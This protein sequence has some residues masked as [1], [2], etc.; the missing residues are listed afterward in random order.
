MAPVWSVN[1]A[2]VCECQSSMATDC[3]N[4]GGEGEASEVE[5][6]QRVGGHQEIIGRDILNKLPAKLRVG[7]SE[8]LLRINTVDD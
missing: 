6:H 3:S 5:G 4:A 8:L 2:A 1:R 7:L